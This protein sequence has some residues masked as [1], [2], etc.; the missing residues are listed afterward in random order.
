M[1]GDFSV[2]DEQY[3]FSVRPG[4]MFRR[5]ATMVEWAAQFLGFLFVFGTFAVVASTT[6]LSG[7]S[8]D[9]FEGGILMI[10]VVAATIFFWIGT[11]G[12]AIELQVDRYRH[13]YRTVVRNH[14]NAERVLEIHP[15]SSVDS[16]FIDKKSADAKTAKLIIRTVNDPQGVILLSGATRALTTLHVVL[17]NLSGPVKKTPLRQKSRAIFNVRPTVAAE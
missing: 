3:G 10:G 2:H 7:T 12:T 9:I 14:R 15:F 1:Y 13:Q 5:R 8:L 11:R 17:T 6:S 4:P 16:A